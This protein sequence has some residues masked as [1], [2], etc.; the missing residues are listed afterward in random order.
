MFLVREKLELC[1]V[2]LPLTWRCFYPVVSFVLL[3]TGPNVIAL[4]DDLCAIT[5]KTCVLNEVDSDGGLSLKCRQVLSKPV[6]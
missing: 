6:I 1:L 3:K 2:L 5:D 4:L